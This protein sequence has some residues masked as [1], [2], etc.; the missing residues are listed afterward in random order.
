MKSCGPASGTLSPITTNPYNDLGCYKWFRRT[1]IRL[2]QY[3]WW[4]NMRSDVASYVQACV[5]CQRSKP[6]GKRPA[7]LL[8][9][10]PI[11]DKFWHAVSMDLIT[12]LPKTAAGHDAIVVFVDM[13]SKMM[14]C[15]PCRS[16][17]T[18]TGLAKLLLDNV[19]RLHGVPARVISDRDVRLTSGFAREFY[20]LLGTPQL[21]STAFHPQT[22]GQTERTNRL[23]EEMLR[24]YVGPR[25]DDWDE[26]LSMCELAINSAHSSS[27]KAS[28]FELLFG[29]NPRIPGIIEQGPVPRP[30][31]HLENMPRR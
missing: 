13:L 16:T 28:P 30:C 29:E 26:H 4:P 15:A 9:P 31:R 25:L 24:S 11:P 5:L 8:Q 19:V 2:G 10:M 21:M 22:D 12:G 18:S 6:E 17:V 14:H 23:L 1:E 27:V 7:G 20:A 3:Y